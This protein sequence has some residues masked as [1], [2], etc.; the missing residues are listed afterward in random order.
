MSSP[1]EYRAYE[2]VRGCA[3]CESSQLEAV[4]A[5]ASICRCVR[6]VI[7]GLRNDA[8]SAQALTAIVRGARRILRRDIRPRYEVL[9]PGVESHLSHFTPRTIRRALSEAGFDVVRLGV[10]DAPPTRSR[11]GRAVFAARRALTAVTPWNFG[12]EMLVVARPRRSDAAA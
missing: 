12:A 5:R 9:R 1:A 4:D 3:L 7:L 2:A 10:D 11:P 6:C 8:A